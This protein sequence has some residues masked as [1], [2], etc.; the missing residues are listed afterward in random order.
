MNRKYD[1]SDCIRIL[2][3]CELEFG[4]GGQYE[5]NNEEGLREIIEDFE[6]NPMEVISLLYL[7]DRI[8]KDDEILYCNGRSLKS[9]NENF[10]VKEVIKEFVQN[11]SNNRFIDF[12]NSL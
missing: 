11:E 4:D 3:F 8:K 6:F 5:F 1:I 2:N 9:F 10:I 12:I 7:N